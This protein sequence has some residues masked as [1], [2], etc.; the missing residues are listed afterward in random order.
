MP[1][2]FTSTFTAGP[3]LSTLVDYLPLTSL[4][5]VQLACRQYA[6]LYAYA[7]PTK[8][9]IDE[10]LTRWF[11]DPKSLR[12]ILDENDGLI[13]GSAALQFF[14]QPTAWQPRDI[15]VYCHCLQA[16]TLHQ[17]LLEKQD[18]IFVQ[19]KIG[20]DTMYPV[21]YLREVRYYTCLSAVTRQVEQIQ[22][23]VVGPEPVFDI[24]SVATDPQF[25]HYDPLAA[26]IEG[27]HSTV[28]MNLIMGTQAISLFP[29]TTF[30]R[31]KNHLCTRLDNAKERGVEK[32]VERGW[33]LAE[34]LPRDRAKA[35]NPMRYSRS[36]ADSY[37]WRIS[38]GQQGVSKM[39]TGLHSDEPAPHWTIA[40]TEERIYRRIEGDPE[41]RTS[42]TRV[43]I[44]L[45]RTDWAADKAWRDRS[46]RFYALL[47]SK[48]K[49]RLL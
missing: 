44:Y 5:A 31:H 38:Y 47:G 6:N 35:S 45:M 15:D 30:V 1:V 32:Y 40:E 19:S 24:T 48:G 7:L 12:R 26:I 20:E 37:C 34:V 3:I 13:S 2:T 8:W 25:E 18:C 10:H 9:S 29:N 41:Q 23:V 22:L 17:H 42:M 14:A 28:V 21:Y 49:A 46:Q 33:A 4:R 36:I 27:F 39:S 11:R 43:F 16:E